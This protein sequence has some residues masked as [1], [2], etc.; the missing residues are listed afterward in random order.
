MPDF[1]NS[2]PMIHRELHQV[3]LRLL[4]I[5]NTF[6][7]PDAPAHGSVLVFLPGIREIEE[8][9]EILKNSVDEAVKWFIVPLHSS[10]TIEE[11]RR[12]FEDPPQGFRK[13]ILSTNIAESSVTVPDVVYGKFRIL[14]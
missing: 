5:F 4:R 3:V 14:S 10:I 1:S 6:E 8:M 7:K 12:A 11:Q 13:I 2:E 9:Y